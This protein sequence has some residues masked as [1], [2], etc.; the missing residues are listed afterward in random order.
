[1]AGPDQ[2]RIEL[3]A[4]L[5]ATA[6]ALTA[7]AQ[8]MRHTAK[9]ATEWAVT[10][11]HGAS[12]SA[13]RKAVDDDDDEPI[14]ANG[15]RK[16][17]T[18][19]KD[20]NAPKR[21]ASSYLMFQNDVRKELKESGTSLTNTEVLAMVKDRWQTM[22]EDQKAVYIDRLAKERE[23]YQVAK[24]AYDARSPE[25]VARADAEVAA[26]I[27]LKK[28]TPRVRKPKADK[29]SAPPVAVA[30]ASSSPS[31]H[32]ESD[33]EEDE[34][35]PPTDDEPM[36]LAR[37]APA[38][39]STSESSGDDDDEEEE[40]EEEEEE[41]EPAPKKSKTSKHAAPP[42]PVVKEKKKKSNKA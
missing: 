25:E 21:P 34:H 40:E 7:A 35:V 41:P 14:T 30:A 32:S 24:T 17:V 38:T 3:V 27:A 31:D 20:P 6:D 12:T 10:L 9:L 2:Q 8:V 37:A 28:A 11:D 19:K 16:R 26:A 33:E 1:M 5:S 42:A 36:P 13:K 4:S 22:T 29:I 15:K 23:R 18:K 39:S